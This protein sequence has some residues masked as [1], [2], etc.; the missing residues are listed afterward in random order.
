MIS[1]KLT[2]LSA[3]VLSVFSMSMVAQAQTSQ[4]QSQRFKVGL[5]AGYTNTSLSAN[6]S[7]LVD[8]KYTSRDGFGIN[9]SVEM[10]V[11]KTLFVSTGIS[12][13]QRNYE[14]ERTD[15]RE[16]WYSKYNNDFIS[17]PLLIGGYLINN[18]YTDNGVWVKVAGGIYAEYWAKM[19]IKGRY[20]VFPELQPDGS[21]PYTEVNETYDFSKNENQLRRMSMGL[22]GQVQLGYSLDKLDFY[23]GYSYLHGLT[24]TY[25]YKSPGNTK[26]VRNTYMISIGAAYK[27]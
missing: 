6:I 25:K 22:Q 4:T 3:I 5:D 9:A 7:N 1:K 18:P 20:P 17:V 2:S 15:S 23:A 16:G 10:N 19:K 21:F 24:D 11:W 12:Y 8:S 13:M 27:F 14:F 26:V